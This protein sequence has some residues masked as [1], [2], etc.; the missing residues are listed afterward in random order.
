MLYKSSGGKYYILQLYIKENI[1]MKKILTLAILT[2]ITT[3]LLSGCTS[4]DSSS[5]YYRGWDWD[6]YHSVYNESDFNFYLE[7]S[8]FDFS[9][10]VDENG[11]VLNITEIRIPLTVENR[12]DFFELDDVEFEIIEFPID[13]QVWSTSVFITLKSNKYLY[14][15]YEFFTKSFDYPIPPGGRVD[16]YL[17]IQLNETIEKTYS[18]NE[19]YVCHLEVSY[20]ALYRCNNVTYSPHDY[21]IIGFNIVT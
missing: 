19:I 1:M 16:F 13:I 6:F 14:N 7:T 4:Y 8:I 15:N 2:L 5:R 3:G 11:S 18:N 9:D 21:K 17:T 10:A 12:N 20:D